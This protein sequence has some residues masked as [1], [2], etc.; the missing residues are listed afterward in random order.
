M[1]GYDNDL[2]LLFKAAAAVLAPWIQ[3]SE[4]LAEIA[5][6]GLRAEALKKVVAVYNEVRREGHGQVAKNLAEQVIKLAEEGQTKRAIRLC[7]AIL[8]KDV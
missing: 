2:G 8:E 4:R 6:K 5:L 3:V 1:R 7:K